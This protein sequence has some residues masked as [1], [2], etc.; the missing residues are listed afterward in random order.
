VL[1]QLDDLP[2]AESRPWLVDLIHWG[3]PLTPA[4]ET[5]RTPLYAG[6]LPPAADAIYLCVAAVVALVVGALVFNR[7][8]D[9]IASEA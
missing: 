1:Y 2:G 9:R 8:D 7:V 5:Y 4:I 6:E 3:N